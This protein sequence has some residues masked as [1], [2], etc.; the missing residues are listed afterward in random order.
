VN[1]FYTFTMKTSETAPTGNWSAKATLGGTSFTKPIKIETVMPNRLKVAL[2]LKR[3]ES[4]LLRASNPE[5]T[6]RASACDDPLRIQGTLFGQWL[7][8]ATAAGLK[9]DVKLRLS[10]A[11]TRFDRNA[12]FVFE[13]PAREFA[14]E[15]QEVFEGE[16]DSSGHAAIDRKLGAIQAAPGMLSAAFTSRIFERGGAFSLSYATHT[17]SPYAR[18]VGLKLPKG[19]V[20]RNMLR[21]DVPHTVELAALT[22]AGAATDI[23]EVEVTLYKV[24]WKWWWDKSGDS[25][26]QYA[27]RAHSS[28]VQQDT[29]AIAQGK[30]EWKFE[31]K[32]PA[33]GRYLVRVCDVKGGHCAGQTFYID[34][35]SW[36]GRAQDQSGPAASVLVFTADKERYA[37][38]ETATI[39][40]PETKEGR[41]LFTIENGTSI[42]DARW[43]DFAKD[44]NRVTVPITRAMTPNVYASVTL[45]QP[46]DK[47]NDRPIRLYGVIPLHVTDPQTS[48]APVIEAAAEWKPESVGSVEVSERNKRAMTYTLAVVDEGLLDL[49]SFRTPNLH[50]EFYKRE[51]L[52]VST[53]DLYD[54]VAGAYSAELE[55]LLALGGS[56]VVV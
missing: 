31:I 33:W 2:D 4:D 28:V 13:D 16:L 12:D 50:S 37:V 17:L 35:P 22:E 39:Q 14:S 42:L 48:L 23:E 30:G 43:I 3:D 56:D 41:A 52:G 26:A 1:G 6:R 5:C 29:V 40:L 9:A 7:N 53:W 15:P 25:L 19:D 34:W 24:E 55:R 32:Y 45:I 47:A 8:G 11:A 10:P 36:A 49:T 21:T 18:Y 51:A 27:Q 46:H 20:T 54:A 44:S 38:G